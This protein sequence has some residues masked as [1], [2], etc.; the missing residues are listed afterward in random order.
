MVADLESLLLD[1][2]TGRGGSDHAWGSHVIVAGGAVKGGDLYGIPGPNSTVFPTLAA[3][4][5]DD[6]DSGTNARGRWIP[7]TAI[8]QVGATLTSWLGLPAADLNGVF[9]N[10]PNFSEKHLGF[11]S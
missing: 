6:T 4:G 3:G 9:P 1:I 2:S 10:L 8:E 5:N 7:T 11:M